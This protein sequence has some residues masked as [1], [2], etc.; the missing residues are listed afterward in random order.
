MMINFH[1]TT[2]T[3]LA[4]AVACLLA[5][6]I[7]SSSSNNY[8]PFAAVQAAAATADVPDRTIPKSIANNGD[9]ECAAG[10]DEESCTNT[11][12]SS[13]VVREFIDSQIGQHKV[14]I[15]SKSYCPH[16]ARTKALFK[17]SEFS[18]INVVVHELDKLDNGSDV[19]KTLQQM[20]GQRTVPSV[21]IDGKFVGG[22]SETQA[23]YKSGQLYELLGIQK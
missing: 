19:Q 9:G 21:W 23:A 10:D 1:R 3:L 20:S 11:K 18:Q 4:V 2:T 12:S 16:C 5:M 13:T 17:Q 14:A 15:F 7:S 22:N 6:A 8:A